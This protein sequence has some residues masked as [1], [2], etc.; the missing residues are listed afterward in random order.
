[1]TE[2]SPTHRRPRRY[3]IAT[4]VTAYPKAPAQLEWDRPGLADARR[5]V[6]DLFTTHLGYEHVSDLGLNP[7]EAQLLTELRNFSKSPDRRPDDLVAVYIASHGEVLEDG[8]HV[9]LTSDTDPDDIDDAL[10]TLTLARKILRGTGVR[11]LMLMLDTCFSGQGGNELLA[12]MARLKGH[13][14]DDGESGLAVLTSTQPNELAEAGAFP[15]LLGQAVHSLATAG[16]TPETL[17]LDAVVNAMRNNP[18]RP[19]HQTIGLEIIGL[20]GAIPPFLPNGRHNPRLSHFDLALQQTREWERQADRRVVEY[21]SR[22]LKRAQGHSDPHRAGWWFSGR[23]DALADISRWLVDPPP[24]QPA[25]AVTGGPGSGKTAVLGI[26]AAVSDPGQRRTVPLDGMGLASVPLPPPRTLAAAIY[27]QNLTDQQVLHGIAAAARVPAD[28]VSELVDRLAARPIPSGRPDDR[29][30]TVLVDAL[31]EAATPESLCRNVLRPLIDP[32]TPHLRLLLGTRPHLLD[33]LTTEETG[34]IDLDSEKYADP[35]AIHAYTIRNLLGAHACSPYVTCGN[36]LRTAV[37]RQVARAAGRSFL[38]ARITA[39]TLAAAPG[40]PDPDDPGWVAALPRMPGEAIH[41][42]LTRRLGDQAPEVMDLLR[43]L[44]FAQGQG[45]PWEDIWAPAASAVSG[46]VYTNEHLWRLRSTAGSY[47]VEAIEDGRSVYRL[48]HEAMAEYLRTDQNAQAVHAALTSALRATVPYGADA[49]PDWSRAHPYLRRHLATHAALGGVL[50][51]LVQEPDYLVHAECDTLAPHLRLLTTDE[52]RLHGAVYR[53]SIGTHRP[54]APDERRA[55]LA[56]DA[57]RYGAHETRRALTDRMAA[58]AW[59]PV[60]ASGSGVSPAMHNIL[61]G[62]TGEVLAVACTEIAGQS[63]AVTGSHDSTVRIWDLG[64]GRPVGEPITGHDTPVTSVAC[65]LLDGRPLAVTNSYDSPARVW[66]LETGRP[67]GGSLTGPEIEVDRLICAEF[68]GRPVV[69]TASYHDST[70]RMW[71]LRT[72]RPVGPSLSHLTGWFHAVLCVADGARPYAVTSDRDNTVRVWDLSTGRPIGE[73]CTFPS[74][75]VKAAACGEID[76]RPVVVTLTPGEVR[77]VDLTTGR[78]V[79]DP[80]ST[81]TNAWNELACTRLDGQPVAVATSYDNKVMLWNLRTGRL[82]DSPLTGHTSGVRAVACTRVGGQPVAVTGSRD[83]TVRIWGLNVGHPIGRP[84]A[85]HAG[86]V[87]AV[88]CGR[89]RGGPVVITA[90]TDRTARMWYP[91][92][93][94]A[95][96][97]HGGALAGWSHAP[98]VARLDAPA[99]A[100]ALTTGARPVALTLTTDDRPGI[101]PDMTIWDLETRRIIGRL[102]A[103]NTAR[104]VAAA[105]STHLDGR[106]LAAIGYDDGTSQLW[107]LETYR[108]VGRPLHRRKVSSGA[109]AC[110]RLDGRPVALIGYTDSSVRLWD[111]DSGEPVG[112]PLVG[113]TARVTAVECVEID[114]LPVA[115]T[116]S[117]DKTLRMWDLTTQYPLGRPLIGHTNWVNAMVCTELDGRPVA[118]TGSHD[119]TVRVWDLLRPTAKPTG[120]TMLRLAN[121]CRA[122]AVSDHHLVAAFGNDVA[123]F[124][125]QRAPRYSSTTAHGPER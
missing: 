80:F 45:L 16:Y 116:S 22:F 50:D 66:D 105:A 104:R 94:E 69:V 63:V 99:A 123:F 120:L 118:L 85:G 48:Y 75:P 14:G 10:P 84:A 58:D 107:D 72:H 54:L 43:P 97:Q 7:T 17:A 37:A 1:M 23:H 39:G 34:R 78:P 89:L 86:N 82:I 71:D 31:D 101:G 70:V 64:T 121:H 100:I 26:L 27:A 15:E 62:H 65:A 56:L 11:R 35:E 4:A 92:A 30:L 36:G 53:A 57:A 106:P 6:I 59:K 67:V 108:P 60:H 114:G 125:R 91:P 49:D 8:E 46:H 103:E 93:S 19:A 20:T 52:G 55:V 98:A 18:K 79:G 115:V 40:V 21:E 90:S 81:R 9:L 3:L 73:P 77:V 42:D 24:A 33:P 12:A 122:L 2:T 44:A 28:T 88:A 47:I 102:P 95:I 112:R 38:V 68:D 13:W 111:L 51:E 5:R 41:N 113:H 87:T 25:L 110:T 109:A 83:R 96:E 117:H 74:G 29:P 124:T 61:T 32:G 76:S 119:N